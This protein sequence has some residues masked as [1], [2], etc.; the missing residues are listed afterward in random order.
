MPTMLEFALRRL[1]PF[2]RHGWLI[3]T[4]GFTSREV[5]QLLRAIPDDARGLAVARCASR[6]DVWLPPEPHLVHC[7]HHAW[8][9]LPR[10]VFWYT[11]GDSIEVIAMRIGALGP[12]WGT[13]RALE[14]AC[15]RIAACLNRQPETFGLPRCTWETG[16]ARRWGRR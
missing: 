15:A 13:E 14:I 2:G 6:V 11:R 1:L 9:H 12:A 8:A 4:P 5:R 16:R 10:I 3:R 7:P